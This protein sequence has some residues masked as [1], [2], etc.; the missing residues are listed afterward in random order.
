MNPAD[1]KWLEILKASGWQT[2]A[3][4]VAFLAFWGLVRTGAI[5][6][7]DSPLWEALPALGALICGT[8]TLASIVETRKPVAR[9]DRWRRMRLD[10]RRA[11]DFIPYM[12]KEDKAII[13]YLLHHNQKTFQVGMTGDYAAP[14]ISR[15]IVRQELQH[16]QTFDLGEVPFS[17][18]D[19]IW[20][21][22]ERNRGSFP[23]TPPE[24][25]TEPPPW[26]EPNC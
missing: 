9:I 18:P 15:G 14:L 3:L 25:T 23:Y 17:V 16:G 11:E 21:V 4:A 6:R 2:A 7:S 10:Q 22:L 24:G 19:H 8:L 20:V 5:P 13:G 12:T 1:P 26:K